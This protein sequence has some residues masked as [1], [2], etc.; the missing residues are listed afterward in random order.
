MPGKGRDIVVIGTSSGGLEALD[1]LIGQLPVNF[2]AAIFIVQHLSPQ[3]T[4]AALLHRLGSHKAFRCALAVNREKFR[5]GRI[6]IGRAD[7]HLLIK[8]DHVLVTKGALE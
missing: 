1:E 7:Y 4:G 5:A 3:N 6:Y 8:K 2:P